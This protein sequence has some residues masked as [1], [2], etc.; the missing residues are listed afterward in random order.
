[1][2]I[3]LPECSPCLLIYEARQITRG[4]GKSLYVLIVFYLSP[5][6]IYSANS[7]SILH[8]LLPPSKFRDYQNK[9]CALSF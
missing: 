2:L 6:L 5:P 9:M 8:V 3:N 4:N 7:A 1:M